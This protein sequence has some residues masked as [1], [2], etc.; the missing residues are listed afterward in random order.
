ME[1]GD[2]LKAGNSPD[3]NKYDILNDLQYTSPVGSAN[4]FYIPLLCPLHRYNS[5]AFGI[6]N[7]AV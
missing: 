1:R 5:R 7:F 2:N 6:D 4:C 3:N